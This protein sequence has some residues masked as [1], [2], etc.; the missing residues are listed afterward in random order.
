MLRF[1][2][3]ADKNW[4][5]LG[6]F[7]RQALVLA[8]VAPGSQPLEAW[9]DDS[10]VSPT[11]PLGRQSGLRVRSEY[12]CGVVR[13]VEHDDV[14]TQ[15]NSQ[16]LEGQTTKCGSR[17]VQGCFRC[18]QLTVSDAAMKLQVRIG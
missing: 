17:L 18:E 10:P 15:A 11:I 8:A 7:Q 3:I 6:A 1:Q 12:A 14:V 4:R 13:P 16:R 2:V 5:L 9:G